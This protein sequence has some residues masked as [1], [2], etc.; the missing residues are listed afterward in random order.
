MMEIKLT[1]I[2]EIKLNPKNPRIIKD[3]KFK[4]L[5]NSIKQFP[6]MLELRPIIVDE[7]GIILG[8]NMRYKAALEVGLKEIPTIQSKDLTEE[9]KSQFIIKD[10]LSFGEWDWD[11]LNSE[12]WDTSELA[13]WGLDIPN[14]DT[15]DDDKEDDVD[16]RN[17]QID[18]L[19]QITID[20]QNEAQLEEAYNK[21]LLLGYNAKILQI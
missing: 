10:N 18:N 8:G 19:Y 4:K 1:P 9:M 21:L 14:F 17:I 13:N 7:D 5:V 15:E 2:K 6:K 11:I 12:E 3:S 20:F 16:D